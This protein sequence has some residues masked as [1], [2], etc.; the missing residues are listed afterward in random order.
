LDQIKG[1]K[2]MKTN[3]ILWAIL[4][5]VLIASAGI[6]AFLALPRSA[7][8]AKSNDWVGSWNV[9]ITVVNANATFPGLLTFFTDGN[10]S[11][12]ETPVPFE[13]SGHGNWVRTGPDSAAFTFTYLI[14]SEAPDQWITGTVSGEVKYDPKTDHWNGPFTI[15][16]VDQSGSEVFADTGTMIGTRI[17]VN[18]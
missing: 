17:T 16:L 18:K 6:A 7:V 12:D 15:A 5:V 3:R 10:V 4:G 11:A 13:T 14:G 1:D 2:V 8:G 9:Q